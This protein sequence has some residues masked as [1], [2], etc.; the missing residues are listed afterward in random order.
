MFEWSHLWLVFYSKCTI[1]E[2]MSQKYSFLVPTKTNHA[3]CFH[4]YWSVHNIHMHNHIW[5]KDPYSS[6]TSK[7][8]FSAHGIKSFMLLGYIIISSTLFVCRTCRIFGAFVTI[9]IHREKCACTK[10][11]AL[12]GRW[13]FYCWVMQP[14]FLLLIATIVPAHSYIQMTN[15][16]ILG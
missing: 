4:K 6:R 13:F 3:S 7:Y 15:S 11:T 14:I 12:V 1:K 16:V 2:F 8:L 5:M 10:P 9:L